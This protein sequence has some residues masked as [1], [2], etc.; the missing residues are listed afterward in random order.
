MY[1]L[2]PVTLAAILKVKNNKET[3]IYYLKHTMK[4]AATLKEIVKQAKS[5][6]PLDSA[7]Y[8]PYKYVKLIQELLGYIRD[9]CPDDHKPSEKLVVVT[10]IN[11]KKIVRI[12]T[13]N[14]VPFR[15]PIP[16]EVVAQEPVVTKVYPRRPKSLPHVTPKIDPLYDFT[17]EKLLMSSYMTEN[18]IYLTFISLVHFAIQTMIV[19][20]GKL[21]AKADIVLVAHAPRAVDLADSPMS[22]SI[23]Q[24]TP[25]TRIS[26]TQDKEHSLIMSQGFEESSKPPH[27]HDDPLYESLH[28]DLTSQGS[29]FNVRPVYTLFE[30]LG[31]WTKD[32]PI[33]NVIRD[34]S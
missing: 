20:F 9:T 15:K 17:I 25:S 3:Y 2:D 29:S 24:D 30:S 10:P 8:S 12:T 16:L 7:S 28:E 32:H 13:T 26:S 5:L 27:F 11:K 1:K 14:K 21:Q 31:R 23:N 18:P 22:T 6:N 34:P 19:R 33:A 4:Q